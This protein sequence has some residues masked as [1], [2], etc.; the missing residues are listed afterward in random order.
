M[1]QD[2]LFADLPTDEA[3]KIER[4]INAMEVFREYDTAFPMSYAVAFLMVA[5][6]PGK[7]SSD[8]ARDL[9]LAQAVTSRLMLEIGKKSRHGGEGLG[10]ID[11]LPDPNDLRARKNFLTPKGKTLYRKILAALGRTEA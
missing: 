5:L 4:L 1:R 10:L 9:G 2:E 11:S 6:K 3:L 8:Y 7:G